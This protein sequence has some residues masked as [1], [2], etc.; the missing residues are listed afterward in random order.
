MLRANGIKGITFPKTTSSRP[1]NQVLTQWRIAK[2]WKQAG[3]PMKV[4]DDGTIT[5]VAKENMP[6]PV[7]VYNVDNKG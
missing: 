6:A 5:V 2:A 3:K 7:E 4:D 1:V